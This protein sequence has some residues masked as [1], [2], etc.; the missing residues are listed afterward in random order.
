MRPHAMAEM[1]LCSSALFLLHMS[2]S[3]SLQVFAG[4][5]VDLPLSPSLSFYPSPCLMLCSAISV[6][7]SFFSVTPHPALHDPRD[8]AAFWIHH[9]Y[10]RPAE[11]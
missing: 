10:P 2:S 7:F 6:F 9:R 11:R 5:V 4:I 3:S 1:C 8:L